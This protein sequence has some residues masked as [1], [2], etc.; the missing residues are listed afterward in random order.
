[1]YRLVRCLAVGRLDLPPLIALI[2]LVALMRGRRRCVA[3]ALVAGM[4]VIAAMMANVCVVRIMGVVCR[5]LRC[6]RRRHGRVDAAMPCHRRRARQ[7]C[8]GL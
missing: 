4:R 3:V 2:A 7:R 5:R 6:R 1:M 8:A